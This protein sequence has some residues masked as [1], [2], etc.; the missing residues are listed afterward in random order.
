MYSSTI[1]TQTSEELG[2]VTEHNSEKR[3]QIERNADQSTLK[4]DK[5]EPTMLK[6]DA[7]IQLLSSILII[8]FQK[9]Y[10]GMLIQNNIERFFGN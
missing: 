9:K 1:F 2:H 4:K 5:M 8:T 7:I 10:A 3:A 6:E